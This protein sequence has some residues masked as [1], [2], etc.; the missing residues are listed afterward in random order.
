MKDKQNLLPK[1]FH[2]LGF[3]PEAWSAS[4]ISAVFLSVMG[5][6]MDV[7]NKYRNLDVLKTLV[8]LHGPEK[9]KDFFRDWS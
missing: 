4:D 9:A 3:V 8:K 2:Q 1:E 5:I 6:F 7:S